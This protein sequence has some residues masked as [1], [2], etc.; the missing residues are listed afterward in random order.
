MI[1]IDTNV[2]IRFLVEDDADQSEAVRKWMAMRDAEIPAYVST[3]VLAETVWVLSRR[4]KYP[5]KQVTNILRDL[6]AADG[7]VFEETERLDALLHN[8][9]PATDLADYLISWQA[10][11]GGC[12]YTVTFDRHAAGAI[13][14]MELLA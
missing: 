3:I 13:P 1:G 12:S 8:G 9:E 14:E 2:L 6:L 7:L 5:M 10:A 11:A 4:L